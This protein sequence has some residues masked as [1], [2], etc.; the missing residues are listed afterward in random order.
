MEEARKWLLRVEAEVG[1]P[2][3]STLFTLM[4]LG[5]VGFES[6]EDLEVCYEL[7]D[8]SL[9][10]AKIPKTLKNGI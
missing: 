10:Q 6:G 8:Q 4:N 1:E 2:T 5:K 7:M 3:Y 9:K